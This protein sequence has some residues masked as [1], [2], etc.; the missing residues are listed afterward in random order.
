MPQHVPRGETVTPQLDRLLGWQDEGTRLVEQAVAEADLATASA[1]PGWTRAHLVAHLARNADALVNLLDWAA[2]GLPQ[3]MYAAPGQREQDIE[4][5][6]A[7][8]PDVLRADLLAADARLARTVA[9]LPAA[10]WSARV[11]SAQGRDIPAGEVPWLRVREVWIHL[12]DLGGGPTLH[13]LPA[14]LVDALLTDVTTALGRKPDAPAVALVANGGAAR[15]VV[16]TEPTSTVTGSPAG[17][18][19]WA[20]GRTSGADLSADAL[21]TLPRWL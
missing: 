10:A 20:T 9:G 4:A 17:L 19:G 2:T 18:L 13:D 5:G 1:L 12:V 7:R 14:E 21:P 15:W 8:P 6:A 16:G 11:L 3:P